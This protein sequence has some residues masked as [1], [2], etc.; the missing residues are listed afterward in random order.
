MDAMQGEGMEEGGY[1]MYN[2]SVAEEAA[3]RLSR[4]IQLNEVGGGGERKA[5]F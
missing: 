2:K 1:A 3:V 5:T 4:G